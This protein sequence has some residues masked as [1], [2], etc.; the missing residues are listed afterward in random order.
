MGAAVAQRKSDD[1]NKREP[2]E[3][4]L[5]SLSITSKLKK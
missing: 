3:K 2:K 1:E 4:I 5:S